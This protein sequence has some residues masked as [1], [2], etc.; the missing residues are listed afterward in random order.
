VPSQPFR[1]RILRLTVG[2]ILL[3][4][5]APPAR[6]AAADDRLPDLRIATLTDFRTEQSGGQR[7][8]RFT[9]IATNEGSGPL[10][11]RGTRA[12]LN[13]PHLR[14]QQAIHDTAGGVRL[15]DS[16]ALMEYAADGHDHWHI[17]GLMLYQMWSDDGVTRRGTKVGFCF[18]DSM[19]F[20]S[21]APQAYPQH[22]CG[23][24]GDLTNRMGI[25]P[26]WGDHYPWN[27][28]Y[29]WIDITAIPP[30]DYTVQVVADEANW[31][32]ESNEVNNC[33]W[34]RVTI[35]ASNGPVAVHAADRT[36]L[37]Q[38]ASTARVE[39]QYGNN[40]HETATAVSE[41]VFAPGVPIAYVTTGANF[42]D[43]LAAGAAAGFQGG[44]VILVES[45]RLPALATVELERLN[46]HRIVVV[47]GP[48]V[49]S[50][51][52]AGLIG[53]YQTGGGLTR[54]FGA[55]RYAT[56][57]AVSA[58]AFP[59]PVSTAY[60]ASGATWPDALAAVP[61]AARAGG[62]VLLTRPTSLPD[63]IK[64]E[65]TRLQPNRIVVVGGSG[66]VSDGVM[67]EL[68][69]YHHGGGVSRLAGADRYGT[70]A[71]LSAAHH[72]GGAPL[73]YVATGQN[74]PDAL[75]AGPAAAVRG[76]PTILVGTGTMPPSSGN[77]LYRLNPSRIVLLGGPAVVSKGVQDALLPY[78]TPH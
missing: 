18:M 34:A 76:A 4:G 68:N 53:R 29:Q 74:F 13:E 59:A 27:F 3:A 78:T 73:A 38:P 61:H 14:T 69:G 20:G 22:L 65:L 31:Y 23:D 62:P 70:A 7:L 45:N 10:E 6:V 24:R 8:L 21:T 64:A 2:L 60:V 17:Q 16:R 43:A 51:Y 54:V 1:A 9:T 19:R 71:A 40:R 36:C 57:A 11:A 55:D 58:Q 5:I 77:E 39:R 30:G 48:A 44:P 50:D 72:P 75:A 41:D 47:G 56:A 37:P 67:A 28:V 35:A 52:L 33:A 12:N 32:V 63:P 26:G 46:P 66:A 42:P 49:V 25:S 15:V